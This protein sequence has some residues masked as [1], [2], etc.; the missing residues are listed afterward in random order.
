MSELE[1]KKIYS[2][3]DLLSGFYHVPVYEPHIER[4]A[5]STPL[6]SYEWVFL[7]M[8]LRNA[9]SIFMREMQDI[10]KDLDF[11]KIFV[12]DLI[13]ASDS[14]EEHQEHLRILF[15]RLREKGLMVKGSKV[16]LFATRVKFLGHVLSSEGVSPQEEKIRAVEEW[17]LPKNMT[18]LRGFLGLVGY[19]RKFIYNFADKAKELNNLTK[20]D[21]VIPKTAEEWTKEQ[22][23]SF[24]VL[25]RCLTRAPLLALPNYKGAWDG[26]KP[27]LIQTDAS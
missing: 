10:F 15:E 6:G 24:R 7:P 1:G 27:F 25:K 20:K 14:V 3:L 17:P 8:G 18:E 26:S 23:Y 12:D 21:A 5:M 2:V 16:Q 13:C 9:P 22:L 19:Y 4:T 11:V